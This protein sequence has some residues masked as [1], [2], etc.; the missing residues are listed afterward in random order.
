VR[1][2]CDRLDKHDRCGQ[3]TA[4]G[5]M[6]TVLRPHRALSLLRTTFSSFCVMRRQRV[7]VLAACRRAMQKATD[8][9]VVH[10]RCGALCSKALCH[11]YQHSMPLA[12]GRKAMQ[13]Q[14][15]QHNSQP[16]DPI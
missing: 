6:F 8:Y 15:N 3:A 5:C 13:D 14:Q 1:R 11:R 10:V 2:A 7:L 16:W 12:A 4:A 9:H